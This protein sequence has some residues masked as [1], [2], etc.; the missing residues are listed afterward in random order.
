MQSESICADGC[1]SPPQY[2]SEKSVNLVK[3]TY[4]RRAST[5]D[6]KEDWQID[7]I[8]ADLRL[9]YDNMMSK[10]RLTPLG[11]CVEMLGIYIDFHCMRIF[12]QKRRL[13]FDQLAAVVQS[14]TFQSLVSFL[15][16]ANVLLLVFESDVSVRL[17]FDNYAGTEERGLPPLFQVAETFFTI[18]FSLELLLRL[19]AEEM[20]F[21]VFGSQCR[22]NAFDSCLVCTSVAQSFLGGTSLDPKVAR[23]F[24]V[25]RA[26]RALRIFRLFEAFRELRVLLD[27]I[28]HICFP[29]FWAVVMLS[30]VIVMFGLVFLNGIESYVSAS[31]KSNATVDELMPSFHSAPM[32]FLSLFMCLTNGQ[33]WWYVLKPLKDISI[34][35]VA[36]F[37][38]FIVFL[39][40]GVLNIITSVF[41][42]N[43]SIYAQKDLEMIAVED[44]EQ[45]RYMM[46]QLRDVFDLLDRDGSG[47][48]SMQ[49]FEE[50]TRID[51]V[52]AFFE[53]VLELEAWKAAR[54][55]RL[56]DINGDEKLEKEE[57]VVGCIRLKGGAKNMDQEVISHN[58]TSIKMNM[59]HLKECVFQ[60][61][62]RLAVITL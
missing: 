35:Y 54:F 43:A 10:I 5:Q 39:Q 61:H 51:K 27:S 30:L 36:F 4:A 29:L 48:I 26:S 19:L 45:H 6:Y 11:K 31:E 1:S 18:A 14:K 9:Q 41:V 32:A 12:C 62:D 15:I 13:H 33:S 57:F 7:P 49:E 24:R 55:F 37:V 44:A 58:L 23:V 40:L 60:M 8:G 56:L 38:V 50:W 42:S 53:R 20:T 59:K 47:C 46:S 16:V 34:A 17:A 22:W 21:F 3:E 52:A 2:V 25:L 28:L